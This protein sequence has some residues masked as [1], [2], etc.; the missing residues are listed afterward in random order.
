MPLRARITREL[1]ATRRRSLQHALRAQEPGVLVRGAIVVLLGAGAALAGALELL[2]QALAAKGT[3]AFDGMVRLEIYR[4]CAGL[5][6]FSGFVSFERLWRS[7]DLDVL[8]RLPIPP[9]SVLRLRALESLLL[10]APLVLLGLCAFAPL[11]WH[12][13]PGLLVEAALALLLTVVTSVSAGMAWH[14]FAGDSV[15]RP[16][17][18]AW[19]RRLAGALVLPDRTFLLYSPLLGAASGFLAGLLALIGTAAAARG[20]YGVG[21]LGVALGCGAVPL[22]WRNAE[23]R[24]RRSY[25]GTLAALADGELLGELGESAPGPEFFGR[26]YA[27]RLP[28]RLGILVGKDLR[29]AWRRSRADH[30]LLGTLAILVAVAAAR[31]GA[32]A[33]SLSPSLV[34]GVLVLTQ[35]LAFRLSREHNDAAWL[36]LTLPASIAEQGLA[37]LLAVLFF[38]VMVSPALVYALHQAGMGWLEAAACWAVLSVSGGVMSVSLS[39]SF[40][41]KRRIGLI[42]YGILSVGVLLLL[43][44]GPWA[45]AGGTLL[46]ALI[47]AS[48]LK[49][50]RASLLADLLAR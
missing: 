15:T 7:A 4:V 49:Q 47:S 23:A 26:A 33:H 29:Q 3:E 48:R 19:K 42:L 16:E 14:A 30:L 18:E 1:V 6:A 34:W 12:G 24:I 2:D 20:D 11:A 39:L 28:S 41:T 35:G 37:R 27:E 13:A 21:I 17:W 25:Y 9:A 22:A 45:L 44:W 43:P 50:V 36:W 40:F 32:A 31:S 46:A 38:S 10:M 8:N 5:A